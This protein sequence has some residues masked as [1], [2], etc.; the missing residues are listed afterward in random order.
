MLL[1]HRRVSLWT[2]G[3]SRPG[4]LTLC[5]G[6]SMSGPSCGLWVC[7]NRAS[8]DGPVRQGKVMMLNTGAKVG[9]LDEV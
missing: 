2:Q 4:V 1:V 6:P 9:S 3:I 8:C 5:D 7:R